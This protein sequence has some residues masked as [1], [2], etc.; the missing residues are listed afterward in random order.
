MNSWSKVEKWAIRL[1][2]LIIIIGIVVLFLPKFRNI[3][4]LQRRNSALETENKN[5]EQEI[6]ELRLKRERFKTE[7]EFIESV[8][9]ESGRVKPDEVIFKFTDQEE[10]E[11][12]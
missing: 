12:E 3:R 11:I 1:F 7:P 4:E 8:A 6:K 9:R 2:I 5:I 10:T